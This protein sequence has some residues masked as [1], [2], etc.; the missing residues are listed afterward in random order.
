M[1][2]AAWRG[3]CRGPGL[4][5]GDVYQTHTPPVNRMTDACDYVADGKIVLQMK[6]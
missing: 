3:V 1:V 2:G 4:P 6:L 5:V